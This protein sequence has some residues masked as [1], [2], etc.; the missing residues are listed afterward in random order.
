MPTEVREKRKGYRTGQIHA[1]SPKYANPGRAVLRMLNDRLYEG[2]Y[3]STN[4]KGRREN[5]NIFAKKTR[6]E[7]EENL[8][9]IIA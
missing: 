5:H 9:E 7:C 1:T 3:T 8:A 2:R 4:A 6:E